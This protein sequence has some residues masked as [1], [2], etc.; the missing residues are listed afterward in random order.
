MTVKTFCYQSSQR[1]MAGLYQ[2]LGLQPNRNYRPTG[3]NAARVMSLKLAGINPHYLPAIIGLRDQLTMWAGLD[4]KAKIRVGW[5]GTNIFLEIPKPPKYWKQV[6]IETLEARRMM[7]RGPV[8]TLGL[9][10]QDDPKRINF[11]EAAIAHVLIS[12]QTRSGKTN[13]QKLIGWNLAGHTE[14]DE[15]QMIVFD[16]AKRGYNWRDFDRVSSLAHPVVTTIDEADRV[17]AWLSTEIDRRAEAGYIT[18]AIFCLIDE[19]KALTDD[20][21]IA[22]KYLSRIASVGGEFGIHLVLATQYPQVKLLGGS[23][24]LKRNITT[25]LCGKVD[26]ATAAANALGIAGTGAETLQGYGDFLLKDFDGLARLT[27]A[28]IEERHIEKLPRGEVRRLELPVSEETYRE[29][30]RPQ[31]RPDP[32]EPEHVAVALFDPEASTY[33]RL[34]RKLGVGTTKARRVWD[35]AKAVMGYANKHGYNTDCLT[36]TIE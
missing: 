9:G 34:G 23:S 31:R 29:P 6:T 28:K 8:V 11:K 5:Q 17:L 19:L 1:V 10:L 32:I 35:F 26:D 27:V 16:V 18:P 3:N 7:R 13:T 12:G 25:R 21:E 22:A 20:S 14:P 4:D 33:T 2:E 24:E 36:I 15:A 30:P